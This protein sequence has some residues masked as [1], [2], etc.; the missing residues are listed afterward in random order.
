L[1]FYGDTNEQEMPEEAVR[2]DWGLRVWRRGR[3]GE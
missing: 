3:N 2:E 1:S